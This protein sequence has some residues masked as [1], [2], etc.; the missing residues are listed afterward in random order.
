MMSGLIVAG[1]P[2]MVNT[3]DVPLTPDLLKAAEVL[4]VHGEYV[5]CLIGP[6]E[7]AAW[8]LGAASD[9]SAED[10]CVRQWFDGEFERTVP[11]GLVRLPYEAAARLAQIAQNSAAR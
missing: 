9:H 1:L 6:Q 2:A 3:G 7:E 8:L 11:A 10:V 4:L 5:D